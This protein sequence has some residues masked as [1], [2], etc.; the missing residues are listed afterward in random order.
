MK[1]EKKVAIVNANSFARYYPE[2]IEKLE[3]EVG[4]VERIKVPTDIKAKDLAEKLEGFSYLIVGT[5]PKFSEEFFE[6]V[7]GLEYVA[8]FGIGYNNVDVVGAKKHAVIVSNMPGVLEKEDVAEQAVAL[9]MALTKHVV[10]GCNA[11]HREEWNVDRG[12][13]L[14]NR[15]QNKVV[16]VLGYGNIGSTYGKIMSQ[17]FQCKIIAYD[18]FLSADIIAERGAQKKSLEEVLEQSDIISLHINLTK[19]NYHFLSEEKLSHLKKTAYLI[20]TARGEL[21][22]EFAV[23][24]ALTDGKLAGYGAD[25]TENEPISKDHPLMQTEKC[26]ITP[27]LGTYNWECNKQMCEAIVND[28]IAVSN[29]QRPSVVLEK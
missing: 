18:P 14:G 11:V 13:F 19:D 17:A 7:S 26:V 12:R 21:V 25:V 15:L 3:C 9:T 2:F 6:M 24:K 10:D 27:H 23:A 22:D 5:T 28:V 29:N 4:Q 1:K 8:R 16:G 20:N